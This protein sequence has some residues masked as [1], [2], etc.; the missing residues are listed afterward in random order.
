MLLL[1]VS[2]SFSFLF[3]MILTMEDGER[4]QRTER[5]IE[6]KKGKK[7]NELTCPSSPRHVSGYSHV[8]STTS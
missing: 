1:F 8:P 3:I 5:N 7:A 4:S 2:F 6:M